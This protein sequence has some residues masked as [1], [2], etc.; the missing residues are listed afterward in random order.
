MNPLDAIKYGATVRN[1]LEGKI[2]TGPSLERKAFMPVFASADGMMTANEIDQYPKEKKFV[3]VMPVIGPVMKYDVE[4]GPIGTDSMIQ[5]L[6]TAERDDRIAGVLLKFDTP[7]GMVDGTKTFADVISRYTKPVVAF[8]S[9]GS[10]CSAGYYM[11]C[12]AD[13]IISSQKTDVIGSI[14]VMISFADVK[15]MWEKEG[16][17]FHEIY[18]EQS[19]EKNKIFHEALEGNYKP[20]QEQ[21]LN[22]LAEEFIDFVKAARGRRLKDFEKGVLSGATY[23]AQLSVANG[24]I[25]SI[26]TFEY[27][28]NRVLELSEEKS[29]Q[30]HNNT[31]MKLG[32]IIAA[33]FT[34]KG[35]AATENDDV[36]AEHFAQMEVIAQENERL[37]ADMRRLQESMDESIRNLA[38]AEATNVTITADRDAWKQK[39]E[40]YGSQPG[41]LRTGAAAATEREA[42]VVEMLTAVDHEARALQESI[43]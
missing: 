19:S 43:K 6:L 12:A 7:G 16:V 3:M 10:C 41:A 15:P 35:I 29:K 18:A 25:D 40:E 8:V 4:C 20:L 24:L 38:A 32:K 23:T 30:N 9:D 2:A 17:V 37:A 14:G 33:M 42:K 13:E 31:D 1:I 34:S 28:L 11:A 39:A 22:P 5:T 21:L 27:A 26:N 36:T